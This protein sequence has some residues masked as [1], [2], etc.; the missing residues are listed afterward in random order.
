MALPPKPPLR[1]VKN[2]SDGGIPPRSG[3][4][5]RTLVTTVAV[6]TLVS[7][8]VTMTVYGVH[9]RLTRKKANPA[10]APLDESLVQS[11]FVNTPVA[12]RGGHFVWMPGEPGAPR[13][14]NPGLPNAL[15]YAP[16]QQRP[17]LVPP[18]AAEPPMPAWTNEVLGKLQQN[19]ARLAHVE[20]YLQQLT[21]QQQ[22][23]A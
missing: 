3:V 4:D 6:T 5:W 2:P 1:V 20:Q 9:G 16:G 14:N 18:P 7:V 10:P 19:D 11:P 21:Q 8:A 23:G 13:D 17:Y 15:R 12:L 22:Q